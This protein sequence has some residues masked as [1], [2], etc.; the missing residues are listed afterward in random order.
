M[1]E[2][3]VAAVVV[4]AIGGMIVLAIVQRRGRQ[5]SFWLNITN[6]G[7]KPSRYELQAADPLGVLAFE[8]LLDGDRLPTR[9]MG[10][11][12]P[13]AIVASNQKAAPGPKAGRSKELKK[14]V[15][16]ASGLGGAV[17]GLFSALGNILPSS[18]GDSLTE[19]ASQMRY[20]QTTVQRAQQVSDQASQVSSKVQAPKLPADLAPPQMPAAEPGQPEPLILE[21]GPEAPP[22]IADAADPA[23]MDWVQTPTVDRGQELTVELRV[24]LL[25]A[26][27]MRHYAFTVTS[28]SVEAEQAP[29]I[30]GETK[31][32]IARVFGSLWF[33]PHLIVLVLS[34][35]TVALAF[36]LATA[37][38]LSSGL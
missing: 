12:Q 29:L 13:Q 32:Q 5:Q 23:G 9:I 27:K 6:Q 10:P 8:F 36:W 22:Q 31:I 25:K 35:A 30:S 2:I 33:V 4:I 7:N 19:A 14:K 37:G 11:S 18:L 24:K 1:L 28:R 16:Q 17:A 3:V 21:A 34:L 20:G 38:Y 15:K 26:Q